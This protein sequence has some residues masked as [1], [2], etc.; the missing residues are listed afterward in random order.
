ME[1]VFVLLWT[2]YLSKKC[3]KSWGGVICKIVILALMLPLAFVVGGQLS[4]L[5]NTGHYI[6]V[7]TLSN[8]DAYKDVGRKILLSSTLIIVICLLATVFCAFFP[9]KNLF[10]FI[11][12]FCSQLYTK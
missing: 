6:E 12:D 4:S 2:V 9:K 8:M 5:F 11:S 1:L 7:L 3:L 10:G